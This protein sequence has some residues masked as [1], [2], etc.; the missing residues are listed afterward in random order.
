MEKKTLY[1]PRLERNFELEVCTPRPDQIVGDGSDITI[2]RAIALEK[3]LYELAGAVNFTWKEIGNGA[4]IVDLYDDSGV[5]VVG[6]GDVASKGLTNNIAKSYPEATAWSRAI[7]AAVV[8]YL[9]FEGRV[10]TDASFEVEK[11]YDSTPT[12]SKVIEYESEAEEKEPETYID[13]LAAAMDVVEEEG[14]QEPGDMIFPFGKVK[15]KKISEIITIKDSS[16]LPKSIEPTVGK[17][18]GRTYLEWA[19]ENSASLT[20]EQRNAIRTCLHEIRK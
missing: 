8:R 10:Y 5:H 18:A 20:E 9:G 11:G 7:S 14:P 17:T 6:V 19:V 4:I 3:I 1:S 2:V 13:P 16:I 15:G 12:V